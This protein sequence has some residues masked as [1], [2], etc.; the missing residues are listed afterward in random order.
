MVSEIGANHSNV[1]AQIRM[2][3]N[4]SATIQPASNPTHPDCD[5]ILTLNWFHRKNDVLYTA[6]TAAQQELAKCTMDL[7]NHNTKATMDLTKCLIIEELKIN[8]NAGERDIHTESHI[9]VLEL[10]KTLTMLETTGIK[11]PKSHAIIEQLSAALT[12][13]G[14]VITASNGAAHSKITQLQAA[15]AITTFETTGAGTNTATIEPLK[16]TA[17]LQTNVSKEKTFASLPTPPSTSTPSPV[18]KTPGLAPT[19]KGPLKSFSDAVKSRP[20]EE[21]LTPPPVSTANRTVTTTKRDTTVEPNKPTE[22]TLS[23]FMGL[24][25]DNY[26]KS[27]RQY[28]EIDNFR[29]PP[30]IRP[31]LTNRPAVLRPLNRPLKMMSPQPTTLKRQQLAKAQMSSP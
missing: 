26:G 12:A 20:D 13:I 25:P 21:P 22:S 7:K 4:S 14:D 9:K 30:H 23:H 28:R 3:I 15:L 19:A 29:V 2:T 31:K 16:V 27:T 24:V 8:S 6:V 1:I 5:T 11:M 17:G 18:K 10:T